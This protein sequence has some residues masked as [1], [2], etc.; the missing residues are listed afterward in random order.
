MYIKKYTKK[1]SVLGLLLFFLLPLRTSM[2]QVQRPANQKPKINKGPIQLSID[3]SDDNN[4]SDQIENAQDVIDFLNQMV[5]NQRLTIED[6]DYVITSEHTSSLSGIHHIYYRQAINGIEVRGTEAS[7]H[8]QNGNTLFRSNDRNLIKDINAQVKSS[9]S[10]LS[11]KQAIQT[12]ASQ[13]NYA[14][15][16]NLKQKSGLA[17][18]YQIFED[19][20]I[21]SGEILAKQT[22]AVIPN[23][24]IRM[25]WEI[26]FPEKK[27]SSTWSY[28]IDANS[29]E[30]IDQYDLT[31]SC[32]IL[33]EHEHNHS[34]GPTLLEEDCDD[35][36]YTMLLAENKAV[37]AS[38]VA[39]DGASYTVYALPLESPFFGNRTVVTDPAD[40]TASPFGWHDTNGAAG[41]EFT[42]TRGNNT[43]TY[44]DIGDVNSDT[45]PNN[46]IPGTSPD[47]GASLVFD[48]PLEAVDGQ[49]NPQFSET[50]RSLNAAST[51]TFYWTNVCHDLAYLYGFD[52]ASGNF[53]ENNYGNG[54]TGG[55]SV[56]AEVQDGGGTCNANFLSPPEGVNARMQM[57]VCGTKDGDY[58]NL[59]IVHEYAHGISIRLTGGGANSNSL[60]NQE[61]MGEG[62]SDYYGY[63]WTM[64]A[65]NFNQDRVVGTFLFGDDPFDSGADVN[66]I[67]SFPYSDD[68]S[69]NPQTYQTMINLGNG[70]G[71]PPHQVGEVWAVMLYDL[72][73][74]LIAEQG[75]DPDLYNG[76]GGNNTSLA[77]VT[78][79][80][81]LQPTSPGFVDGRDAIL[82]ADQ[83]LFAGA[84]EC[85]IWEVFAARGL[86]FSADQGSSNNRTDGVEAFDVPSVALEI[87]ETDI[88]LGSGTVSLGSGAVSGGI[89]SGPGV[90]DDGNGS[91]FTFDPLIA[92]TGV[93]TVTYSG[94]VGEVGQLDCDGSTINNIDTITVTE[95][96]PELDTCIDVTLSLDTNGIATFDP[97]SPTD[98]IVVGSNTGAGGQGFSA[99]IVSIT[100]DVSIS[101]DWAHNT[102]DTPGFDDTGYFID[103]VFFPLSDNSATIQSGSQTVALTA[104]QTFGFAVS[105]DDNGFGA[106]T[107]SFTN[108][109]PGYS[110]QFAQSNWSEDLINSDGSA[111]FSGTIVSL[112]RSCG[113]ITT[114]VSQNMFTCLDIG[115]TPVSITVTDSLGNQDTCMVNVT[116]NGGA[117][118]TTTFTGGSWNNGDPT[119]TSMA[120][121]NDDYDTATLGDINACSCQ[122]NTNQT[123]TVRDGDFM[124]IAGNIVVDG[125]LIVENAG[126]VVQIDDGAITT[127]NGTIEVQKITPLL[128]P[129]DFIL[130]SSPMSGETRTGVFNSADRVFGIITSEFTPDPM[131]MV[132]I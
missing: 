52:E 24:G 95:V 64:D 81:K 77:L 102:E 35:T 33:G 97:F 13:K 114:T 69:V 130:L 41:A 106:A 44:D 5:N 61:Q 58:D 126:S 22:Y 50:N 4:A 23:D 36:S 17:S 8:I 62:W 60:N 120:I 72:T 127:N 84:N 1:I 91:T 9:I 92:G 80:L 56:N 89:Y 68:T 55:D 83:A 38:A 37:N 122:I 93:H 63:M 39:T 7:V 119:G 104:G 59:V 131:K 124:N 43:Y 65:S 12:I 74:A 28:S 108:F 125:T 31:V 18:G 70:T 21:A 86:G 42:I 109:N 67:R 66:G 32:N 116:V 103:D 14:S 34:E 115:T 27:S 107:G 129:R 98:V 15:I 49:G 110:G 105:T 79:A 46:D 123:V 132:A 47:G 88:C 40:P 45:T 26:I 128:Q 25:I 94:Q 57:F 101:F 76:T 82:A 71:V 78:E 6:I 16:S 118:N 111:S 53:Q 73:Q 112:L 20:T 96:L 113:E 121:V 54:G 51:N 30:I 48:F 29:G 2:A 100:E 87:S 90:T 3:V 11:A 19:L 85:L 10:S 99:L 117:L 75:F